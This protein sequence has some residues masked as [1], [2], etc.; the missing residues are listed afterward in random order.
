MHIA[1]IGCGYVGLVTGACL[2]DSGNH[3]VAVDVDEERLRRLSAGRSPIFEPGLEELLRANLAAG[4]LRF[5]S[6]LAAAVAAARVVFITVG[7]PA[8]DD[9]SPDVSAIE[10]VA[11]A[12]GA[13]LRGAA[14][15]VLKSTAPVGSCRRL[16]SLIAARTTQPFHVVSNPE[17][18]KEGSAVDDFLRPDRVVIGAADAEAGEIVAELYR[19][20]VRNNK[21]I[22]LMSREAAELTKYAA[23]AYLATRI[24]FINEMAELCERFGADVDEVRRGIGADER[25]G[26]H[27]LYPGL[28]YGG[29]CFPKDVQALAHA[30]RLAGADCGLLDAVHRRN[31]FQRE[32][33]LARIRARIGPEL[34]HRRI[35]VWGLAFKPKTDDVRDAPAISLIQAL[36]NDGAA[37]A[38]H[39]PRALGT[40]RTVLGERVSFC[41]D[42]Y[43]AL[44]GADALLVCTEWM[45]YRSPDFERMRNAMRQP[46]IFDGRN[47]YDPARVASYN[48]EYHSIG[49]PAVHSA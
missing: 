27:F 39:D 34:R 20:F 11:S 9:G 19:P 29:S 33:M 17:F 2:A 7:T 40:A 37:V 13:A 6:D 1:V 44:D 26:H 18:L 10:S 8:R 25:I 22:L 3:V 41:D 47:I 5:T 42:A 23:N 38:A 36:L 32:N 45:E 21:P 49:R 4:R 16:E 43:A 46:L 35:A 14:V 30:G 12:I 24:S 28:G 15:I 48:F 31:V